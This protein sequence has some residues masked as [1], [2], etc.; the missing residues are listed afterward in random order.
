MISHSGNVFGLGEVGDFETE[1]FSKHRTLLEL[2]IIELI[3]E[4]A[5]FYTRCY[6]YVAV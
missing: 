3:T 6:V 2:Q 1:A 5:I 4:P